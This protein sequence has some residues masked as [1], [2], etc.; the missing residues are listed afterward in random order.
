MG[1]EAAGL[2]ITRGESL[3]EEEAGGL[4][5]GQVRAFRAESRLGLGRM[6]GQLT[7]HVLPAYLC[8]SPGLGVA[9]RG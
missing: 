7:L 8:G 4:G 2:E 1:A 5:A 3:V 6:L 9:G